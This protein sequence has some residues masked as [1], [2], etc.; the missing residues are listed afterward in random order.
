MLGLLLAVVAYYLI[1]PL[2]QVMGVASL[3]SQT[4]CLGCHGMPFP[5]NPQCGILLGVTNERSVD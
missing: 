5:I 1:P 3:H 4:C 2:Q